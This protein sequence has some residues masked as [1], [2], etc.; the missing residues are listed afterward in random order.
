[1][2]RF[3]L[4]KILSDLYVFILIETQDHLF[5]KNVKKIYISLLKILGVLMLKAK[6]MIKA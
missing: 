2:V 4:G 3:T 5:L 1:M 6:L